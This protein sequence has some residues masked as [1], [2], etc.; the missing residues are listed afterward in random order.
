MQYIRSWWPC[1][2]QKT[3]TVP[4]LTEKITGCAFAPRCAEAM[5][6]C[7]QIRPRMLNLSRDDASFAAAPGTEHFCAC[8]RNEIGSRMPS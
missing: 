2:L 1:F 8:H 5:P 4:P 6:V 7:P 3:G